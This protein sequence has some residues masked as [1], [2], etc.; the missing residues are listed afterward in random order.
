[1]YGM[2]IAG[3]FNQAITLNEMIISK[4]AQGKLKSCQ[5]HL[6]LSYTGTHNWHVFAKPFSDFLP[7]DMH[8]S[9]Q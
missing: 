1:M 5:G 3:S 2:Q 8:S 4:N 7:K 6:I 9:T